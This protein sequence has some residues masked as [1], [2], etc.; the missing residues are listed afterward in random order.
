LHIPAT[1]RGVIGL[2]EGR[3]IC[4]SIHVDAIIWA[5]RDPCL[6]VVRFYSLPLVPGGPLPS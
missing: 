6:S 2:L 3:T 4:R 5:S 1:W